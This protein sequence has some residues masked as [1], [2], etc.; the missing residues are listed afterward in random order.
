[1][2]AFIEHKL[3]ALDPVQRLYYMGP[4]FRYERPQKGRYRQFHQ[5]GAEVTGVTAPPPPPAHEPAHEPALTGAARAPAPACRPA[6]PP[7]LERPRPL[8]RAPAPTTAAD[9]VPG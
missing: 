5:I 3:H 8:L 7:S 6:P 4:M 2:R 1:M 9:V